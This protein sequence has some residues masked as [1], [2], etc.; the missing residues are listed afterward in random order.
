MN[1]PKKTEKK[2]GLKKSNPTG[3]KK[4]NAKPASDQKAIFNEED[5]E[6]DMPLDE[7]ES[8]DNFNEYDDEEDY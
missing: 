7:I 8:F 2:K 3:V 4:L 1:T 6:F 5:E